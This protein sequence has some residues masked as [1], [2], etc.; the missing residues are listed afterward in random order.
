MAKISSPVWSIARGSI[1]GT[2]YL[3]GPHN[4]IIARARTAPVNPQSNRQQ[5]IRSGMSNAQAIWEGLTEATRQLW[6]NYA[7]TVVYQG[8][9]GP[10]KPSGQ[11]MFMAYHVP[12]LYMNDQYA[13]SLNV[14][15]SAPT[16]AGLHKIGA[17]SF[18]APSVAGTGFQLTIGNADVLAAKALIRVS[19]PFGSNRYFWKGPYDPAQSQILTCAGSASSPVDIL[20]LTEDA[21]YFVQVRLFDSAAQHRISERRYLRCIAAVTV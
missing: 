8:P 13:A 3:S 16:G 4:A 7:T 5:S 17:L 1:A 14:S 18:A 19:P 15:G 10:Y 6:K 20:G 21:I 2:T 9:L 11:E 12:A